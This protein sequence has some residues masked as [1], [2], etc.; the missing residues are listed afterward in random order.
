MFDSFAMM[1][2]SYS[3]MSSSQTTSSMS[4]IMTTPY[5]SASEILAMKTVVK[6]LLLKSGQYQ[7]IKANLRSSIFA[8]KSQPIVS[9]KN[10]SDLQLDV[11]REWLEL[12]GLK[13][14]L[15]VLDAEVGATNKTSDSF[16]P[17]LKRGFQIKASLPVL[18][19]L[20]LHALEGCNATGAEIMVSPSAAKT[21]ER[22][23]NNTEDKE[24]LKNVFLI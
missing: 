4:S 9:R 15:S 11:V 18:D 8:V 23:A 6:E 3:V 5:V 16:K 1:L 19:Q 24:Y 22:T 7:S 13:F 2:N 12:Q 20:V 21:V 17:L 10:V 14:T